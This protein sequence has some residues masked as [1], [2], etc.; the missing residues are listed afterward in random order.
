MMGL[1]IFS[2]G[3]SKKNINKGKISGT[4][5][6]E[7]QVIEDKFYRYGEEKPFTGKIIVRDDED[8]V[9]TVEEVKDG[10][11]EGKFESYYETGD[12][13]EE[14]SIKNDKIE[15]Q[16][17]W[18]GK[19]GSI[20]IS[21]VYKNN[22]RESEQAISTKDK[23]PFTGTYTETYEN[24][25]IAQTIKFSNGKRDGETI[26][27]YDSGKIRERIPYSN[28]LREGN[29][30]YYNDSGW[31]TMRMRRPRERRYIQEDLRKDLTRYTMKMEN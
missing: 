15:G 26:F 9:E 3:Q 18:Y 14:Y 12:L 29:Y 8:R 16:Y 23:K 24:G 22:E 5:I 7:L 27:Y 17:K 25:N 19:D 1:L 4:D 31:Y 30:F 11:I 20:E 28:G 10:V 13:K 21:A 6:T 2:C